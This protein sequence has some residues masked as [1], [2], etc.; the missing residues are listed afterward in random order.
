MVG[1]AAAL[2]QLVQLHDATSVPCTDPPTFA[3]VAGEG[4]IGKTRLLRALVD[5]VHDAAG[6]GGD[7]VVVLAGG[8]EPDSLDRPFSAAASV[9]GHWVDSDRT[10][11]WVE[12]FVER[13]RDRRG[14]VVVEDLH[15]A[16]GQSVAVIDQLSRERLTQ[17][18]VVGS[19]RPEDLS[20]R[21]PGG[22]LLS[23]LE[24]RQLVERV[25][26]DP[27]TR[28]EVGLLLS[29]LLDAPPSS[30]TIEAVHL[31]SGGNPFVVEELVASCCA[32]CPEELAAASLPW[33]LE[34]AVRTRLEG[35]QAVER[36][37]IDAA[38][39]C[40]SASA[41]DVL[42]D[43][44]DVSEDELIAVLR[45]LVDQGLL[46]ESSDDHFDFRHALVRDAVSS[47]LLG[48]ERRRLHQRALDALTA[49]APDDIA[50]RAR[51][52]A[53][54]GRY[55]ELVDLAREGVRAYLDRGSSFVALRLADLA[56]REEPDDPVLRAAA[57]EAAWRVDLDHEA[58][59]HALHWRGLVGD[60]PSELVDV[61]SWLVRVRYEL[62]EVNPYRACR[63]ELE[64]L[65]SGL[66]EDHP[67]FARGAAAMAQVHMLR[68]EV[69]SAVAWAE[70]AERAAQSC[71]DD[72]VAIQARIE[73]WSALVQ[74]LGEGA[75]AGLEA[76]VADA[77]AHGLWVLAARGVNNL[78]ELTPMYLP[79]GEEL[80]ERFRAAS[81]RA[82][83]DW[84]TMSATHFREIDRAFR[85]GDQ[86]AARQGIERVAES[87]RFHPRAQGWARELEI[88]L[89]LEEGRLDRA[90]VAL[91]E[92][93]ADLGASWA[94]RC[95]EPP[96]FGGMALALAV[97]AQRGDASSAT[98]LVQRL[99]ELPL[100]GDRSTLTAV[101]EV[102]GSARAAGIADQHLERLVLPWVASHP[103]GADAAEFSAALLAIGPD[104]RWAAER[105]A[106][107]LDDP[108]LPMR[109]PVRAT[110]HLDVAQAFLAAG[111][112]ER[113]A[114]HVE[115]AEQAL[116]RWP[117]WRRDRAAALRRRLDSRGAQ[118]ADGELT[119]REREVASLLAEGLT[120]G[121]LA[122]R[123]FISPKTAAVHVSNI[124]MKL[125][126]SSRAEIAAWAV[127]TGLASEP[128][129]G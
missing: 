117:G 93:D 60:D 126:M 86:A 96:A 109:G 2:A 61:L 95:G 21:L 11:P 15:W 38:S 107:A 48:R 72:E 49:R 111:D 114:A 83:F 67:A 106:S 73:R 16:D 121:Q 55:D 94:D 101:L 90:E 53:G 22:E 57:T 12:A 76:A 85:D 102:V 100:G 129:A 69:D 120:N 87:T 19:Y 113:A 25:R 17:L 23:R 37:V 3:L 24:R 42:A 115:R 98:R 112:R 30:A 35:L 47:Q 79:G 68:A 56:L 104:P 97:A 82:G 62:D 81:E 110:F 92:L 88:Y 45:S 27:L 4:G 65:V 26:L 59:Q 9:L 74:R 20:R 128:V 32:S 46:V 28:P 123:L 70:R 63:A 51:L 33:S 127:R 5:V 75:R 14:L 54:A 108:W 36:R 6:D 52:A 31:R 99:V 34:D 116:H 125:Q 58:L 89:L 118:A 124:L 119:V 8:A 105:M 50:T 10:E 29:A 7:P 43:V 40:G 91:R 66:P 122:E 1:R 84:V 71:G 39:V 64:Q 41:F 77:E 103:D 18:L 44:A 80:L 78:F 13:L